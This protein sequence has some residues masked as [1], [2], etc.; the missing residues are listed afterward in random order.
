VNFPIVATVLLPLT[1]VIL[2]WRLKSKMTDNWEKR[3]LDLEALQ[4]ANQISDPR[5]FGVL[6]AMLG[7]FVLALCLSFLHHTEPFW[8][9]MMA[10]IVCAM[11]FDRNHIG[12]FLEFVEWDTLFFFA[13]LFVLVEGLVELGV[14]QWL[15][16]GIIDLIKSFPESSRMYM[17]IVIILWASSMGSAFLESLP[18]TM[19]ITGILKGMQPIPGVKI[20]LLVW[21]LSIGCCIGGIGSIMGSSANIVCMAVSARYAQV[22]E[23]EVKG[24]DFL[25]YGFPTLL[26]LTTIS[27]VWLFFLFEWLE[28]DPM[29]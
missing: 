4:D 17:A 14:I 21:P 26:V 23:E 2:F 24:G 20:N 19:V 6:A 12:K 1:T 10:M 7:S 28:F 9:S 29:A 25:R 15:G 16:E 13:L 3:T 18:Y 8:F 27:T 22:E 11:F 5:M